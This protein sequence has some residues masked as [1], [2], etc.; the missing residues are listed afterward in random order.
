[1]AIKK[2]KI[3]L[4]ENAWYFIPSIII[5]YLLYATNLFYTASV[6]DKSLSIYAFIN[7]IESCYKVFQA[8][9]AYEGNLLLVSNAVYGVAF[10][11]GILLALGVFISFA[12]NVTYYFFYSK[13]RIR[14]IF[15]NGCDILIADD[16]VAEVYLKTYKNAVLLVQSIPNKEQKKAFREKGIVYF[17]SEFNDYS[18]LSRFRRYV[19]NGKDYNFICLKEHD[20][21]LK[22]VA[23]FKNFVSHTKSENFYLHVEFDY[24]NYKSVNEVVLE[25]REFT[26]FINCFNANELVARKFVQ[27]Y[28]I[29]KFVPSEFFDYDRAII[30]EGKKINVFYVGFGRIPSALFGAS[31]INDRL[32]TEKDNKLVE[33]FVNYYIYD[34]EGYKNESKNFAFYNDRYFYESYNQDEFFAPIKEN[35]NI[36]YRCF[37]IEHKDGSHDYQHKLCECK[38]DFN[39]IV[40]SLGSD[41]ENIDTAIKTVMYLRQ[42]DI[43]NFH[44]FIRLKTVR[45]EYKS[46]FDTQK[47]TFF[48]DNT[49]SINHSVIVDEALMARAKTLNR[50]Y[51]E[52]KNAIIKWTKLSAI[53]KLSNVYAGL[54]LRLKLNLLGYDLQEN[55]GKNFDK[56]LNEELISRLEKQTPSADA[57]YADYLFFNKDGF[58]SANALSYQ[59]KL[60]WNAFYIANGYALMKKN[61]IKVISENEIIK[62]NDLKKLHACLTTVE[63]LDEYHKL[64]A[65]KLSKI[66]GKTIDEEL[67]NVNTYKYDYSVLDVIKSFDENSPMVII[68]R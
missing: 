26:A 56:K 36:D 60:R 59:E 40:I 46:F 45:E 12:I 5:L 14:K 27:S 58:N 11:M 7:I 61:D 25:D 15:R 57:P 2:R 49:F 20:W 35:D 43:Q 65:E 47:I 68:R 22:V 66:S 1:M 3:S 38:D 6:S 19:N 39:N 32:V 63:G 62:D 29:T 8:V 37:D 24:K 52:K 21:T 13:I 34:K 51:E 28:P 67:I 33:A 10:F 42:N 18:I 44:I 48:G 53:K 54:N 4:A 50:S 55:D 41:V 16:E 30:K 17:V 23:V 9:V 31:I 64:L